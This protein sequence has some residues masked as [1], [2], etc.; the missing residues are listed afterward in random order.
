MIILAIILYTLYLRKENIKRVEQRKLNQV[1]RELK[2]Q[3]KIEDFE[4]Y[5]SRVLQCN[6]TIIRYN[7]RS[8]IFNPPKVKTLYI[9]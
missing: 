8:N 2:L 6:T 5:K 3:N 7:I 9:N 1:N 4:E